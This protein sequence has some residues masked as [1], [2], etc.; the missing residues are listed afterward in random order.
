MLVGASLKPGATTCVGLPGT[1]RP[2]N[3]WRSM[4]KRHLSHGNEIASPVLTPRYR[5]GGLKRLR[6]GLPLCGGGG[7]R[8][9]GRQ[10][11]T[12]RDVSAPRGTT[13]GHDKTTVNPR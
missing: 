7:A 3:S 8:V 9:S 13:L 10:Q 6:N 1:A 12:G 2:T 5:L 11:P 4:K